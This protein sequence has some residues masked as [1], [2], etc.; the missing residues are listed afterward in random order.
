[1]W[2][3]EVGGI[4]CGE[5]EPA[6]VAAFV[7]RQCAVE[8]E[9]VVIDVQPL[10][11]GLESRAVARIQA[12]AI[13]CPDTVRSFTFV[14]KRLDGPGNRELA[15]YELLA[16]TGARAIPELVGVQFVSP[17]TSY[18]FLEWIP[19]SRWPWAEHALVSH[20]LEQLADLHTALS[21]APLGA[22]DYESELLPSARATLDTLEMALD[23]RALAGLRRLSPAMRRVVAEL[24]SMRRQ[25]MASR[26]L[27]Q[28][29]LHGDVHS[30]NVLIREV[31]GTRC[32]VLLDWARARLGSPLEDVSSWL[33]SLSYWEPGVR[34]QRTSLLRHYLH[35][36]GLPPGV[37]REAYVWYWVA[38]AS[39]ALAGAL[40][41]HLQAA[42]RV[43]ESSPRRQADAVRAVRDYLRAIELADLL[44]RNEVVPQMVMIIKG[45][46][47]AGSV[48]PLHDC[49]AGVVG[50]EGLPTRGTDAVERAENLAN[51]TSVSDDD[52]PLAAMSSGD[53]AYTVQNTLAEVAVAL[54]TGPLEAIV[55]LPQIGAPQDRIALLHL[56][57]WDAFE[58]PAVDLAQ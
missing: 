4:V 24:P 35:A 33:E 8:V 34:R 41:Y 55:D 47:V 43:G 31:S 14:V 58:P 13:I 56:G 45:A 9:R 10:L 51:H 17:G 2:D 6:H 27:G 16:A 54:T 44:W 49:E 7:R 53:S 39:N 30:G 22:W 5:L 21:V 3:S 11:G 12:E 15:M 46:Q 29:V 57:Q 42:M 23:T 50:A 37:L 25:L 28:A 1:M 40:R 48:G 20:V 19:T 32:P 26:P 52:D 18:L 38:A 36:R